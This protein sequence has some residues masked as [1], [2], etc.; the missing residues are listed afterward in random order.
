VDPAR[1]AARLEVV[2]IA[3]LLAAAIERLHDNGSIVE[4]VE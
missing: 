2:E 3:P 4:L 1:A